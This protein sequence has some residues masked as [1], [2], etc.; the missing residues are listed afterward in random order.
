M[1]RRGESAS[2]VRS[3]LLHVTAVAAAVSLCDTHNNSLCVKDPRDIELAVRLVEQQQ[4]QE[5]QW[6]KEEL[7]L[8]LLIF[9][10]VQLSLLLTS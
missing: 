6:R 7:S 10:K 8:L 5:Q 3:R 9:I 4:L 1:K 2:A